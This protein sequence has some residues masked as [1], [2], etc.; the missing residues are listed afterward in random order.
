MNK[1]NKILQT[2]LILL[3][4]S[5][6]ITTKCLPSE[7]AKKPLA[8]GFGENERY[9]LYNNGE[10]HKLLSQNQTEQFSKISFKSE[11]AE[12]AI[13]DFEI[14]EENL[15]LYQYTSLTAT[16]GKTTITVYNLTNGEKTYTKTYEFTVTQENQTQKVI[17][18]MVQAASACKKGFAVIKANTTHA[19]IEAYS[20]EKGKIQLKATYSGRMAM[21]L[22]R[23][24]DTIIA[25]TF[26][27][28]IKDNKTWV[29]PQITDLMENKTLLQLPSLVPVAAL[30]YPFIQVFNKNGLW[31]SYVSVYNPT[32]KRMEYY[33][34]YPE[35][36]Q[37]LEGPAKVSPYMDYLILDQKT[38]SKITFKNGQNITVNQ[39][40]S[41]I[42]QGAHIPL[43]PQ[44]GILDANPT[45]K[46]LLAKIVG[47]DKAKILLI[48]EKTT[49]TIY[50]LNA[51][52]AL[53]TE[54]FYAALTPDTAYIINPEKSELVAIS[55]E[56]Q[57]KTNNW[58]ATLIIAIGFT[59]IAVTATTAIIIVRRKAKSKQEKGEKSKAKTPKK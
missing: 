54:G 38:G 37:E 18:E 33:L 3:I 14:Y 45:N 41:I 21:T 23:Y 16:S 50:T 57:E 13:I 20:L 19:Q 42:P 35:K 4:A 2:L 17:G 51:T 10:I 46:T 15:Y 59:T 29:T 8:I 56:N 39:K 32:M 6:T 58:P 31:E 55:L 47:D 5:A 22:H 27:I 25:A 52:K 36:F 53:K 9:I 49:K 44:N 40:L 48:T 7:N 43:N 1:N 34:A 12:S 28:E 30:A 24:G 26:K 11:E